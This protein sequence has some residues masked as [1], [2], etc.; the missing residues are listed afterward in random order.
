MKEEECTLAVPRYLEIKQQLYDEIQTKP[1][2]SPIASERDLAIT[3]DA[4]RMTVRN[5][6][7][8]LVEE[9]KLYR[10]KNKGTFVAA[11]AL[12]KKNTAADILQKGQDQDFTI[13]YY[14]I[15]DAESFA[16]YL[17]IHAEDKILRI[18]RVNTCEGRPQSIE[19]MYFRKDMIDHKDVN[20]LRSLLNFDALIHQ[21]SVTQRFH[22]VI[23]PTKYAN[24]LHL[25]MNVPL[26]MIESTIY[27]KSGNP[28]LF[29]R[30]YYNPNEKTIEITT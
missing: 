25:K 11:H 4:S 24:L 6:I 3:Y 10:D 16:K 21:G 27:H 30:S 12:M 14:S 13:I 5:A 15:K 9:G 26:L 23:V 2:N 17:N 20:N 19:E 29:I 8:E 7:N 1:E 22:A 18:V 28:M